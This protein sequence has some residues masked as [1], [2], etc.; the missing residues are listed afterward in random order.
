[1]LTLNAVMITSVD[2]VL[3]N[4]LLTAKAE[5]KNLLKGVPLLNC[6]IHIHR[7]RRTNDPWS[8]RATYALLVPGIVV[9]AAADTP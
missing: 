7:R 2:E 9:A 3:I 6:Y 8:P 5:C 1:M 4:T